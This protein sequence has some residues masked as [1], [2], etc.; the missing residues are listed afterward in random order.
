VDWDEP[1]SLP[2][3]DRV[4]LSLL[5]ALTVR[6]MTLGDAMAYADGLFGPEPCYNSTLRVKP[7]GAA[8]VGVGRWAG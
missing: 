6:R 1:I 5:E 8:R 4:Y 3:T 7:D 2:Y